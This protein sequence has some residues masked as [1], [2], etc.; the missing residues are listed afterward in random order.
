MISNSYESL[1]K[2]PVKIDSGV[3]CARNFSLT[4]SHD[5]ANL[6]KMCDTIYFLDN[7]QLIEI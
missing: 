2:L 1:G 6:K 3:D 7:G 5:L 4:I